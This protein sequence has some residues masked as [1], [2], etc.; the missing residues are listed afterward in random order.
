MTSGHSHA[1]PII[2]VMGVSGSGKTTIARA[3]AERLSCRMLEGDDLHPAANI[4]RMR[5][6]V[7]LTDEDRSA[8]LLSIERQISA[9]AHDSEALV[10]SC[11]ALKRRYRD[12]LRKHVSRVIFVYLR[13]ER[14]LLASRLI[15]R[16]DH[17]MPPALLDSQLEALE[18]PGTDEWAIRL[19]ITRAPQAIVD[20]ILEQLPPLLDCVG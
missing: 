6:G 14:E 4:E 7:P 18:P 3:L 15:R 10:V 1:P 17:F 13:G 20:S 12:T 16:H 8:W 5:A 19:S 11:S 9:A 2:V